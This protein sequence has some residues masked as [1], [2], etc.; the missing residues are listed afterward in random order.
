M[1]KV[2]KKY[3]VKKKKMKKQSTKKTTIGGCM[4]SIITRKVAPDNPQI[5][6]END[7]GE[8]L[9]ILNGRG[10]VDGQ[11]TWATAG[12]ALRKKLERIYG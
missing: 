1:P 8:A 3:Q 6:L 9:L 4:L 11:C 12:V 5:I 7:K 10:L 2:R